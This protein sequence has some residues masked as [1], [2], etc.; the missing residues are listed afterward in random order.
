MKKAKKRPIVLLL[1]ASGIAL[2]IVLQ[3]FTEIKV[4]RESLLRAM[5][6]AEITQ[7]EY[8][9]AEVIFDEPAISDSAKSGKDVYLPMS[10]LEDVIKDILPEK[11]DFVHVYTY[12]DG[13]SYIAGVEYG[14]GYINTEIEMPESDRGYVTKTITVFNRDRGAEPYL[15]Q[16]DSIRAVYKNKNNESFSKVKKLSDFSA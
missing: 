2:S 11:T 3:S 7:E 15:L 8:Y 14:Q 1:I 12:L 4:S 16:G 10:E 6:N 13:D 5:P 9:L